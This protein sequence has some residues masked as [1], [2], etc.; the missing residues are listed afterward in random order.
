MN[1][2]VA[3]EPE[4]Y[5]DIDY[6]EPEPLK[7]R[8]LDI[9]QLGGLISYGGGVD[10]SAL[11][12]LLINRGWR[13]HIA[14]ADT[15]AE[16]PETYCFMDYFEASWLRPRGLAITHLKGMPW[17]RVG[18]GE[19]LIEKCQRN[20][21]IP[22]LFNRWCTVEWK[23]KPLARYAKSLGLDP[24]NT[25]VGIDAGEAWRQKGRNC[26]LV[27]EGID[28]QGCV[29]IIR[30]E[31]LEVPRKSGCWICP[32]QR[33]SQWRQLWQEHPD[34][35]ERAAR[36]EENAGRNERSKR[37]NVTLDPHGRFTLRQL[38]RGFEAQMVMWSEDDM[39]ALREYQPCVCS[40]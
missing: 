10:S 29:E 30:A 37:S 12:I 36:L 17:Q 16:M 19:T 11:V 14:F 6:W 24:A 27:E 20:R 5:W 9:T 38:Q 2:E 15:G 7:P 21:V 33:I 1:C 35:F 25:M 34:L 13:G 26:P 28:R 4:T 8:G 32:G 3:E 18:G 31:G 39:D 40:L 23:I 22:L